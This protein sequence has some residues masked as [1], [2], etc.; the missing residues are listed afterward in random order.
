MECEGWI[1]KAI[2]LHWNDIIHHLNERKFKESY[3]LTELGNETPIKTM[4]MFDL[5]KKKDWNPLIL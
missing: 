5:S 3:D 4:S 2:E 1:F